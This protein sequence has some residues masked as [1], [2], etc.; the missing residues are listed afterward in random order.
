MHPS[1]IQGYPQDD[2]IDDKESKKGREGG[3][4]FLGLHRKPINLL[5]S[6]ESSGKKN[7]ERKKEK[8]RK[9]DTGRPSFGE[10]GP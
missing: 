4:I 3:L 6:K 2:G 5:C 8:E 9:N 7:R 10:R 1:R